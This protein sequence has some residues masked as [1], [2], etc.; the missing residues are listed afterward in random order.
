M[1]VRYCQT[2]Y[3]TC[4]M[5]I[6]IMSNLLQFCVDIVRVN[7]SSDIGVVLLYVLLSK[8]LTCCMLLRIDR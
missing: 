7:I 8:L 6:M 3:S 2:L 4:D 5:F 1:S